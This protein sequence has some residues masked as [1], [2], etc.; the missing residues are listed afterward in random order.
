M[1]LEYRV[2]DSGRGQGGRVTLHCSVSREELLEEYGG[3]H[4]MAAQCGTRAQRVGWSRETRET[5][6]QWPSERG[7]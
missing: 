7:Q 4:T 2:G 5:A 3:T 6:V 1:W